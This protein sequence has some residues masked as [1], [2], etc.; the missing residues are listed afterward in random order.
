MELY[1]VKLWND[2][3]QFKKKVTK[4]LWKEEQVK[5]HWEK[6]FVMPVCEFGGAIDPVSG[7]TEMD[8]LNEILKSKNQVFSRHEDHGRVTYKLETLH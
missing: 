6:T 2:Y 1:E 8:A 7:M 5:K 4:A 3:D